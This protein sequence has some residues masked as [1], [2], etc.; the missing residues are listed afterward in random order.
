MVLP[1]RQVSKHWNCS[2]E[3]SKD[4]ENREVREELNDNQHNRLKKPKDNS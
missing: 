2:R 3:S 1:H 4:G